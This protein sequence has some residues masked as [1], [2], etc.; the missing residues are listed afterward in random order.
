MTGRDASMTL[1]RVIR[2][3]K[4]HITGTPEK[5]DPVEMTRGQRDK[6]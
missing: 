2:N 5:F 6:E 3:A 4:T 1:V